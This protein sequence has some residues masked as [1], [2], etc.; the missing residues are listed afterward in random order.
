MEKREDGE[1]AQARLERSALEALD[2]GDREAALAVLMDGY[3]SALYR[4]C[5]QM[6]RDDHL[7]EDA[8]QL[9]FVQAYEG[10]SRFERRSSLRTWLFGIARHRCLDAIKSARRRGSRFEALDDLAEEAA[11]DAE[12]EEHVLRTKVS[13]ILAGCLEQLKPPV[14]TAVLLRYREGF[15]YPEMARICEAQPATLQARV[16]RALP[17]LRRCLEAQGVT[18]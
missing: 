10:F 3:G 12:Q 6:V 2:R 11:S 5:R 14:R 4:F 15:S 13:R 7:A 17:G 8:H 18:P 1:F 9:A 16:A